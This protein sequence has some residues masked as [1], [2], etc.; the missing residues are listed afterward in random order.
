[1]GNIGELAMVD[2]NSVATCL[3]K[4]VVER[5]IS[6]EGFFWGGEGLSGK[7]SYVYAININPWWGGVVYMLRETESGLLVRGT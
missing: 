7:D 1:M 2:K 3:D 6:L 5:E 4:A